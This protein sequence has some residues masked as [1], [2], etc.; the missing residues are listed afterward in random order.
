MS[1]PYVIVYVVKSKET[2]RYFDGLFGSTSTPV[3]AHHFENPPEVA[4]DCEVE[5]FR[6]FWEKVGAST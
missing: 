5:A 6:I 4:E 2:G 1:K 3:G